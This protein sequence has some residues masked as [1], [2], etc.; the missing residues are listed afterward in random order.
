ME[1]RQLEYL[2]AVVEEGGFTRAAERLHVAQP[3]VSAQIRRLEAELG[4]PLLDRGAGRGGVGVGVGGAGGVGVGGAGAGGA[5]G[6]RGVRP[7]AAGEALL[8]HA[9]AALAAVAQGRQAVEELR[10]LVRGQVAVGVV[11]AC[12]AIELAAPLAAFHDAHPGIEVTL[13]EDASDRLVAGLRDGG[14]DLAVIGSFGPPVPGLATLPLADEPLVAAVAPGDPLLDAATP[15]P[16]ARAANRRATAARDGAAGGGAARGAEPD[17]GAAGGGAARG[18]EPD[19]GAAGG[20]AARGAEPDDGGAAPLRALRDRP[21]VLLPRGTGIRSALEAGC[22]RAGFQPRVAFEASSP[23][24][25]ASLAARGLGV[26]VMAQSMAAIEPSL[27][28]VALTRPALRS[29]LELAWR[30]DGPSS[31][32]ARALVGHLHAALA[33]PPA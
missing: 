28:T 11:T 3:G 25:L 2:V 1:L 29:R 14:L 27:R 7:T 9:R 33:P 18:A 20:G 4:E 30:A 10:G 32:A 13:A 22:E 8:P 19:D 6:G 17:D 15:R 24:L 16:P 5:G 26:A 31:P 12:P 23:A 21:L